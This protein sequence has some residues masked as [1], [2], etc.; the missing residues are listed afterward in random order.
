MMPYIALKRRKKIDP[1]VKSLFDVLK[2]KGEVT[3]AV[4]KL[5]HLWVLTYRNYMCYF[6]LSEAKSILVDALDEFKRSVMDK[7]ED[8]KREE[9][10]PVSELDK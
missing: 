5:I 7:Y 3:Y 4:T 9:N 2:S 1:F 8:K 6:A 10:G